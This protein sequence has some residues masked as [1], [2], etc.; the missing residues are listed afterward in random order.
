MTS[1][2]RTAGLVRARI[3]FECGAGS[4]I[5]AAVVGGMSR[6]RGKR[7]AAL[8]ASPVGDYEIT[9]SLI[10]PLGRLA[11]YDVTVTNGS[12]QITPATPRIEI[13]AVGPFVYDGLSH[14][15][16]VAAFGVFGE[17]LSPVTVAYNGQAMLPGNAGTHEVTASF[18][19][20]G[21]YASA[22]ATS[23]LLINRAPL[24]VT[25]QDA[26]REFGAANPTFDVSY[27]GFVPGDDSSNLD[28]TL[29]F[30][31][32]ASVSSPV[33]T[34]PVMPAGLTGLNYNIAFRPGTLTIVDTT[35]P[36][37]L[38]VSPSPAT[39]WPVTNKLV[40][41][42][43]FAVA[44]DAVDPSPSCRVT[45]VQNSE[46]TTT[47]DWRLTGPLSVELRASR[48]GK[49]LGRNYGITVS[50]SD[51]AGNTSTSVVNVSVPHDQ[52]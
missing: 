20:V 5:L 40:P 33:G 22:S 1:S 39:L 42:D 48:L 19:G 35:A 31:T 25:A 29:T 51:I 4:S 49:G 18:A 47:E 30:E 10:D 46:S 2:D 45:G 3:A 8:A 28:G 17:Q 14:G 32:T 37:I 34:Y 21:N 11:N 9:A 12:L 50:C 26:S 7:R 36:E 13:A 38:S 15:T 44:R 43:I 23:S 16:A 52:R 41:V 24:S 6:E 27:V